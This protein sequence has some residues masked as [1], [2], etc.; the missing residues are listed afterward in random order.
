MK[1]DLVP[2]LIAASMLISF[3]VLGISCERRVWNECRASGRSTLYCWR[4]MSK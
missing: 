3:I 2:R 1:D 4:M